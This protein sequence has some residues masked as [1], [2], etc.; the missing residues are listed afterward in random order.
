MGTTY[1]WE[2]GRLDI[3]L[4]EQEQ[5]VQEVRDV[6]QGA[7]SFNELPAGGSRRQHVV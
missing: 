1:D 2:D 3:G 5:G 7:Q 6:S 4:C